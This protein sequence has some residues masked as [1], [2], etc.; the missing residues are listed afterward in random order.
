MHACSP[1]HYGEFQDP[2][3]LLT[4]TSDLRAFFIRMKWVVEFLIHRC[5]QLQLDPARVDQ[6]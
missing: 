4:L 1:N 6:E 2:D 5:S 3:P